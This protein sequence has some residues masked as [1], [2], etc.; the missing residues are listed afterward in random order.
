MKYIKTEE[1]FLNCFS[2]SLYGKI[3]K[4]STIR[5]KRLINKN[6]Y[7]QIIKDLFLNI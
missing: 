4:R 3:V 5:S 7:K 6:K 2:K 1:E